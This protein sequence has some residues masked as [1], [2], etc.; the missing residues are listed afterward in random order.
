MDPLRPRPPHPIYMD[1]DP[2]D[3]LRDVAVQADEA[4][5]PALAATAAQDKAHNVAL[6]A[7]WLDARLALSGIAEA[8][9]GT[10]ARFVLGRLPARHVSALADLVGADL[11]RNADVRNL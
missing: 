2:Q 4:A 6:V 9:D 8:L 10:I 11:V 7:D 5:D 3:D 1:R